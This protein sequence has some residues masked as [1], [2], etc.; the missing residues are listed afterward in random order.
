MTKDEYINHEV[1]IRIQER[2][3][4]DT[5]K[6]LNALIGICLTAVLIPVCLKFWGI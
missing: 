5:N 2:L 6:K 3:S 4:N 1:R